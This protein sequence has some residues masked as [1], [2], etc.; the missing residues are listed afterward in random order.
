[1]HTT[2]LSWAVSTEAWLSSL[3]FIK[4]WQYPPR[5]RMLFYIVSNLWSIHRGLVSLGMLFYIKSSLGMLFYNFFRGT[6]KLQVPQAAVERV[7]ILAQVVSTQKFA[8]FSFQQF[9]K[10]N[11]I[12]RRRRCHDDDHRSQKD[13][14]FC[15]DNNPRPGYYNAFHEA[16]FEWCIARDRQHYAEK[17]NKKVR[18]KYKPVWGM[19]VETPS[20]WATVFFYYLEKFKE[21]QWQAFSDTFAPRLYDSYNH[22]PCAKPAHVP[23]AWPSPGPWPDSKC[24]KTV[25]VGCSCQEKKNLLAQDSHWRN[26]RNTNDR[27]SGNTKARLSVHW[28]A[29]CHAKWQGGGREFQ[30]IAGFEPILLHL[31][32]LATTT[33]PWVLITLPKKKGQR[34][35]IFR[36]L[37]TIFCVQDCHSRIA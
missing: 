34:V 37:K 12:H 27:D 3:Y 10:N 20:A 29:Q 22:C 31:L 23:A 36:N 9:R 11:L 18:S 15:P 30:P 8:K 4:P 6:W 21:N 2:L 7:Y 33:K 13:Y 28:Q 25:E 14:D 35:V 19:R 16:Q 5:Q 26:S 32:R 24:P 1:M 17:A